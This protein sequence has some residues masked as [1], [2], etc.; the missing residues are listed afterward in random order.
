MNDCETLFTAAEIARAAGT[1]RQ[2]M[3]KR[4]AAVPRDGEK[5]DK[6][7]TKQTACAWRYESLPDDI[8]LKVESIAKRKSYPN[9]QSLIAAPFTRFQLT[10]AKGR[11]MCLAELSPLAIDRARKLRDA[12]RPLIP[13][14]NDLR[15]TD[16][17]FAARGVTEYRAV[18]GYNIQPKH[19]C[20]LFNRTVKERDNGAEEW[21]RLEIYVE[22]NPALRSIGVISI[23]RA[24]DKQFELLEATL[25]ELSEVPQ[26]TIEHREQL[27]TRCCDELQIA[28]NGRGNAKKS[29]R[30]ILKVLY[31]SRLLGGDFET[32][33]RT[34]A[35]KWDAYLANGG[36]RLVDRR[37]LRAKEFLPIEDEHV[38]TAHAQVNGD[39]VTRGWQSALASGDLSVDT[40]S[41]YFGNSSVPD[42]VRRQ[43][44]PKVRSLSA[45]AKGEGDEDGPSQH[46]DYSRLCA[47]EVFEMDDWTPEHVCWD[48]CD[49]MPGVHIF[50]GQVIALIDQAS[51][52]VLEFGFVEGAYHGRVIRSTL[53]N[54]CK[55]YCLPDRLHIEGG[56]WERARIIV[57]RRTGI[58][59]FDQ[60]ELGLREFMQVT[61]ARKARAKAN[62]ENHF[63]ALGREMRPWIGWCGRD[64]RATIP[65]ELERQIQLARSGK[66]HP[67]S[68]CMSKQ[69]AIDAIEQS[70]ERY[71]GRPQPYGR[72][73]GLSPNDAWNR[74]QSATGRPSLGRAGAYLI[75][76]QR[77]PMVIR[78]G[79]IV[80]K[81]GRVPHFYHS[82]DTA[83]FDRQRIL[84]WSH[85]DDAEQIAFT[86][87]DRKQGPFVVSLQEWTPQHASPDYSAI[88]RVQ[89][90]IS[91]TNAV[92]RSEYRAIQP[93]LAKARLRPTLI[94]EP[95]AEL[96]DRLEV[97]VVESKLRAAAT[98]QVTRRAKDLA[99]QT[100][101]IRSGSIS[102]ER[103]TAV[104]EGIRAML[105][106]A[107]EGE[108]E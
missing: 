73:R 57:G 90:K 81:I 22:P 65:R 5:F 93:H 71:N 31:D 55:H 26:L 53:N 103:A 45:H 105:E 21:N 50:Q 34:F 49:D 106:G 44:T 27:W 100:G 72:L 51:R 84:V 8:R 78:K 2:Y 23:I 63:N 62:I 33:R 58:S 89:A 76:Y 11:R 98:A 7:A 36:M 1:S 60:W 18:F 69:Q 108:H 47:G 95:T 68:F 17:E 94:D 20:A 107:T 91:E 35:R 104:S 41:R 97:Q 56:L 83:R 30:A 24:R 77:E 6:Y 74:M 39:D 46:G 70:L 29:K 101:F 43:V 42:R 9:S 28:I 16:A 15:L 3:H 4:L 48:R 99:R 96:G 92:R 79:Q 59:S 102:D 19:W 37:R 88:A 12:L 66:I 13:L 38:V 80:R 85:P 52:R 87:L 86:S 32:L 61:H 10:D 67:S 64:M 25:S 82:P 14:R 54:A 40:I 75:D